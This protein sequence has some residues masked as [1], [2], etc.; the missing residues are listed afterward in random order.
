MSSSY[1][2]NIKLLNQNTNQ[3]TNQNQLKPFIKWVGGKSKISQQILQIILKI[4]KNKETYCEPFIGRGAVLF[5]IVNNI[6]LFKFNKFII[7]DINTTLINTYKYIKTNI[8]E[9]INE[10]KILETLND[11][12]NYSNIR[13][14]YNNIN[15]SIHKS[16]LFIYLNKT[17]FRGL[18]RVNKSNEFNVPYGNYKALNFDYDNLIHIHN[19]FNNPNITFEFYNLEYSELLQ[20]KN[21]VYY[22]DPPYFETFNDYS[23]NN[24]DSNKFYN[25]ISTILNENNQ[26]L[27]FSNSIEFS[28]TFD[29]SLFNKIEIT[30]NDSI[31]SKN[32][33]NIRHEILCYI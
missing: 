2:F 17:C 12:N 25:I 22:L 15:E 21:C 27:I 33:N 3:N 30:L 28:N 31:N 29:L 14:E 20:N 32:P 7:N 6:H 13:N 23:S 5:E 26:N 1:Y 4:S 11:K 24:F 19:T 18:Y 9:L 16:A 10:L 8:N